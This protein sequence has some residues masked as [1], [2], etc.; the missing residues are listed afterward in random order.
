MPICN[1]QA[2]GH[3][4]DLLTTEMQVKRIIRYATKVS[5]T[6]TPRP[7]LMALLVRFQRP[8][9]FSGRCKLDGL[10]STQLRDEQTGSM[11]FTLPE[12]R[13]CAFWQLGGGLTFLSLVLD[14]IIPFSPSQ[15]CVGLLKSFVIVR[16]LEAQYP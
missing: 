7:G 16:I 5:K 1:I 10:R 4:F 6:T 9:I 8:F 11:N 2:S 12:M 13:P 3:C 14:Y 15:P